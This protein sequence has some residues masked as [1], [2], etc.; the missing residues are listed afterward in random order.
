M[1]KQLLGS[2]TVDTFKIRDELDWK[3]PFLWHQGLNKTAQ[4]YLNERRGL[5]K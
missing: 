2:L 4:W 5:K 3:S 1:Q